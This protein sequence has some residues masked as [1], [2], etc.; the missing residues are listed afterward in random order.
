YDIVEDHAA[1]AVARKAGGS[2]PA[3]H[4][5]NIQTISVLR[6]R[7]VHRGG[8]AIQVGA[9]LV[10][11]GRTDDVEVRPCAYI[12]IKGGQK[13]VSVIG[14]GQCVAE[15]GGHHQ[16]ACAQQPC[17]SHF[18]HLD[19]WEGWWSDFRGATPQGDRTQ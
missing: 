8:Y 14:N 9:G 17:H 7:R 6:D 3:V 2:R 4:T 11:R 18:H 12:S 13:V 16:S 19:S 10:E 1:D 5:P 15:H